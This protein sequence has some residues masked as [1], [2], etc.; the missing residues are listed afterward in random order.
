MSA[1]KG[2][3]VACLGNGLDYERSKAKTS[4]FWFCL[5]NALIFITFTVGVTL[6][7]SYTE[8][9]VMY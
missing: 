4:G 7:R 9:S 5:Y 3:V 1:E 2:R 8:V 6:N